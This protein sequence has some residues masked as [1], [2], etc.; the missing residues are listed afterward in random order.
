MVTGNNCKKMKA[1][2]VALFALFGTTFCVDDPKT[3]IVKIQSDSTECSGLLLADM[4]STQPT[5][6]A[7]LVVTVYICSR[8]H[9]RARAGAATCALL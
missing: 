7:F 1:G 3:S 5:T 6:V 2:L 8:V 9:A 4:G